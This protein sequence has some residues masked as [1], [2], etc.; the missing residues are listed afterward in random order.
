MLRSDL[1]QRLHYRFAQ[2]NQK[3]VETSVS[4]LLDGIRDRLA[5]GGRVEVRGFG[6]FF[7]NV[8]QARTG[9]NPKTGQSVSVPAKIAPHFRAGKALA[10]A[11][12]TSTKTE[13]E[14][15]TL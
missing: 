1:I 7:L 13:N 9:R 2:F 5:S 14:T 4:V 15:S 6:C 8:R 12:D 11:V 10:E 3:D